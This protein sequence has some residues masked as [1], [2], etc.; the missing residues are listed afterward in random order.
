LVADN[1]LFQVILYSS[2]GTYLIIMIFA[3]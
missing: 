1:D 2:S 3:N